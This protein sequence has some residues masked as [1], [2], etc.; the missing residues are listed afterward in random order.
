MRLA[1]YV[2][3]GRIPMLAAGIAL[4]FV[5]STAL[6]QRTETLNTGSVVKVKLDQE[7]NSRTARVGERFTATVVQGQDDFG[8]PYGTKFEGV[9]REAVRHEGDK[10]GVLDV[11]FTRIIFPNR[12]SKNIS[13]NLVSLSDKSVSR[14]SNGRLVSKGS[15]DSER[16]KWV[17]IG[18]GAGLLL[19]T[20]TKSNSVLTTILGAGLG[21]LYNETQNKKPGDVALKAGTEFGVRMD[22]A[23]AFAPDNY[24]SYYRNSPNIDPYADPN[25]RYYNDP[26]RDRTTADRYSDDRYYND[27]NSPDRYNTERY[28]PDRNSSDRYNSEDRYYYRDRNSASRDIRV[29]VDGREVRFTTDKPFMQTGTVMVPFS[30]VARA[31]GIRY[32]YNSANRTLTIRG[33]DVRMSLDDRFATVNGQRTR[34]RA[35]AEPRNG[36]LFVPTDFVALAFDGDAVYD[37]S[38]GM[39]EINS[40]VIER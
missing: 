28:N 34:M 5:N 32:T 8:L 36:I 4:T 30:P 16:F 23:F 26:A 15:G 24:R 11:D 6:A 29:L 27:P 37:S 1:D 38:R 19:S 7:L 22:R 9:V 18:A 17:G 25:D 10:P 20:I 40:H 2:R 39:V 12:D 13:A 35:P 14:N 31:A 33:Q 21:Y 3:R